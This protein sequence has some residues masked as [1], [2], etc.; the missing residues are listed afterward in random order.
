VEVRS[1]SVWIAG[2]CCGAVCRQRRATLRRGPVLLL[3]LLGSGCADC[4]FLS[5]TCPQPPDPHLAAQLPAPT[6]SYRLGCPDVLQ[7]RF[8]DYPEWDV[9]AVVDLDGRL[10]LESPGPLH[11]EGRTLEAV[12][13]E[14]A[15]M[16]Q[17]PVERVTVQLAAPR[18]SRIYLHGPIRGRTR[19]VPYQGPEPVIDFLKR[20]GGLPP[21]SKLSEV[22]VVRPNVAAGQRPE[23]FP[24]DVRAV[25]I[26][27]NPATNIPLRPSDTVY[28]GETNRSAIAR[29]LPHWLGRI[30]RHFAGLLPDDWWPRNR[31]RRP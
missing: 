8:A 11:V 9:L 29:L 16:A 3:L 4:R 25:L 27:N 30:Y 19:I 22:Y 2:R 20:V 14:L 12:R 15:R 5:Q 26:D 23:V 13:E 18:A 21:G 10:P 6:A 28:I 17:V 7:I 31:S 1:G 24:V